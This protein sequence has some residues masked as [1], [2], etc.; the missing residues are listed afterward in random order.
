MEP[1]AWMIRYR[2]RMQMKT[3]VHL[4]NAVADYRDAFDP[5]AVAVP[6]YADGGKPHLA[7]AE[8]LHAELWDAKS[9]S[10]PSYDDE[11]AAVRVALEASGY[12]A[13]KDHGV[14]EYTS[15]T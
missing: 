11:V 13:V 14:G 9:R 5:E 2:H 1:I 3:V 8:K 4:H 12:V 7:D 15:A 6:L 10:F